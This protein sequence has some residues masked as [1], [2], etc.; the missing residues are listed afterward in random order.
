MPVLLV[1]VAQLGA[2]LAAIRA[3]AKRVNLELDV[4]LV[5][6]GAHL[7]LAPP[8]LISPAY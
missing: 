7:H 5:S 4:V 1:L 8:F 6:V 3:A 2:L